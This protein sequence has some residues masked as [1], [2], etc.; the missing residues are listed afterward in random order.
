MNS[1]DGAK[2]IDWE[3]VKHLLKL[4]MFA[5]LM[6]FA[7]DMILGWGTY[8]YDAEGLPPMFA[9][10]LLVSDGRIIASALLGCH[11]RKGWE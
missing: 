6:V 8:Y 11:G 1:N 7:A 3:R 4:G 2:E 9:R 10:F 5:A